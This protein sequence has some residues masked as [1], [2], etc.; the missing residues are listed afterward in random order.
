M[1]G[2]MAACATNPPLPPPPPHYIE[3]AKTLQPPSRNSLWID[4][5]S[6]YEDPRA[7]RL[8]DLVTVRVVENIS[9]S[10]NADTSASRDSSVDMGVD[11]VAGVSPMITGVDF[12]GKGKTF[13]PTFK[14]AT[15]NDF[16][17]SGA[18]A[19]TGK[20]IGTI[21][22]KIVEVM[23]NG[24]LALE[25]RK[26]ITINRERQILILRGMIRPEDI[27]NDNTVLSSQV[28]DAQVY[29]VGDGVVQEK[30][31]PGWLSRFLDKVTPF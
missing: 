25:S 28:A 14:G 6:L 2:L 30:Q 31:G 12:F 23:P 16:K 18:T 19:R 3:G 20:L 15:K 10:G 26:E 24:N 1:A 8:N 13:S 27:A 11:S 17:G 5:A 22:A 21:T 7:R 29:Y 4:G 9:G